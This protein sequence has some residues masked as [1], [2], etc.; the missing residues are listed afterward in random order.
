MRPALRAGL[1]LG[2]LA[3]LLLFLP[4]EPS[5]PLTLIL[6]GD[7]MLGRGV[8]RAL[9]DRWDEAFIAVR[10]WL[11]GADVVL[12]NL[13][14]PLTHAP[15]A[16]RGHDLRAD[17][18][19]VRSLTAAGFDAVSLANN[20][21][22]DGGVRGRA[23]TVAT[24]R[25][26]GIGA[27][28]AERPLTLSTRRGAVRVLALDDSRGSVDVGAAARA[29]SSA[30]ARG[31]LVVVSIHWG[32]EYQAAPGAR[33]RALARA[34]VEA[35][36]DVVVG[37]G[38]HTLQR[39]TWIED[40]L[41]AYSLGNFLFDQPYP[42]DCRWGAALRVTWRAGRIRQV[43]ALP[44]ISAAGRVRRA[45][46]EEERAILRRLDFPGKILHN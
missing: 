29:I 19:A 12:A 4:G 44:T 1:A 36:A 42:V 23:E 14:S 22:L 17:P 41:V 5:R 33:Q 34:F 40:R 39:V 25:A 7:V 3:S 18:A 37:H 10:P 21:A 6:V 24:L 26:A 13:E 43:E 28:T 35:G 16:T 31:E 27:A 9:N 20:H 30:A 8:A 32:G 38:P 15:P 45:S 2:L 46:A 11:A